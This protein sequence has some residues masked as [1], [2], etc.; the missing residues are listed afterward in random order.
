MSDLSTSSASAGAGCSRAAMEQ[1]R[2]RSDGAAMLQQ[3]QPRTVGHIDTQLTH[4]HPPACTRRSMN[5]L[6]HCCTVRRHRRRGQRPGP[7]G[8]AP[9]AP[10]PGLPSR[11]SGK[12][13]SFCDFSPCLG[14]I[15]IV[16][17]TTIC[18]YERAAA[19]PR[20][21]AA[22]ARLSAWQAAARAR[23]AASER[24]RRH[25]SGRSSHGAADAHTGRLGRRCALRGSRACG[26][27]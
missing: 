24:R 20:R 16:A 9:A 25:P 1:Q 3:L 18:R 17:S 2:S 8:A 21:A 19:A 15:Y 14:Q 6:C 4:C 13:F 11:R 27:V 10:S 22:A 12:P 23:E 5:T 26:A 7:P